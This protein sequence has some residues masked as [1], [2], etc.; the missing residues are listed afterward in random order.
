MLFLFSNP[1]KTYNVLTHIHQG[2]L[3]TLPTGEARVSQAG[4][5]VVLSK[6]FLGSDHDVHSRYMDAMA[7]IT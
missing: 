2:L 1:R 4:R 6:D 5:R 7:L 3:D